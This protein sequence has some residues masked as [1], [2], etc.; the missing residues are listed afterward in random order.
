VNLTGPHLP[1]AAADGP[2]HLDDDQP[3]HL[4]AASVGTLLS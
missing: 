2:L 3:L 4:D 1:R